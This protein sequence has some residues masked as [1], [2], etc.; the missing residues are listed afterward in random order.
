M[1]NIAIKTVILFFTSQLLFFWPVSAQSS[2]HFAVK[3]S[4]EVQEEPPQIKLDWPLITGIEQYVIYKR[5]YGQK[6]WGYLANLPG[7]VTQYAD[8]DVIPGRIYEYGIFKKPSWIYD[9]IMVAGG[10]DLVFQIN[11]SW[12]DGICY[13]LGNG[14]YCA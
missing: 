5:E 6:E 8:D 12:G 14:Y 11:D 2:A 10:D 4:A 3:V 13:W 9:T 7:L 1:K